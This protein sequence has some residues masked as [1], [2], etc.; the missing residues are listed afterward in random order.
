MVGIVAVRAAYA[1]LQVR[2]PRKIA[3]LFAVLVAI[4]AAGAGFCC[5][6]VLENEDLR[7]VSTAFNVRFAWSV[8][9]FTAMPLRPFFRIQRRHIV[10]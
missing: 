4:Q 5:G 6:G 8:A 1:I 3:V 7:L 10:R 2:R 9:R